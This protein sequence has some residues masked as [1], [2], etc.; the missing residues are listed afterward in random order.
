MNNIIAD[1]HL[2]FRTDTPDVTFCY[3][4]SIIRYGKRIIVTI[5]IGGEKE[6][7]Y[8]DEKYSEYE[9]QMTGV[10]LV[11]D[12]DGETFQIKGYFPYYHA[13]LVKDG[14]TIYII[15][16]NK[17]IMIKASYDGGESWS[18]SEKLTNNKWYCM[19]ATGYIEHNGYCYVPCEEFVDH[20]LLTHAWEPAG[21]APVL[22]RA[23]KGDDWL[24]PENWVISHSKTFIDC[25]GL[26]KRFPYFGVPFLDCASK[27][28]LLIEGRDMSPIG[29]LESNVVKIYDKDHAFYDENAFH[30]F[31]RTHTGGT[32]YCA[33]VKI[34]E[35]DNG[36]MNMEFQT[37]PSGDEI[38]FLPLPGGQMKFRILYDEVTKL[39][40]LLSTQ[41]TDSMV[42][43]YKLPENR[44]NLPNNERHRLQLHF[45]KNMVDWCFA[46]MIAM[47]EDAKQSRHYGDMVIDGDDLLIVARSGDKDASTAHNGNI[48]TFHKV[49]DFRKLVY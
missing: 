49:K 15:G 7:Y 19:A 13:R 46:G 32:G 37:A 27:T 14:N 34:V 31:M 45:S 40:W 29:W 33:M 21:T 24:K 12:D 2:I 25:F 23:K 11:S 42:D 3:S 47:G 20:K 17:D 18:E 39:Y 1:E 26:G 35:N 4:P 5:D 8:S 22:L 28:S 16:H 30:I 10:I 9:R 41:A 48:I 6:K 36:S 38:V 44:Y 43:I